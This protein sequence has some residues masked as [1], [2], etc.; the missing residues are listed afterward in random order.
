[1]SIRER[2]V[3]IIKSKKTLGVLGF[4][5]TF[6][7][8]VVVRPYLEVSVKNIAEKRYSLKELTY[9]V[10]KIAHYQKFELR[11]V[12]ESQGIEFFNL[13]LDDPFLSDYYLAKIILRNRKGSIN[14]SLRFEVSTDTRLA[15]IIDVKFKITRPAN[16]SVAIVHSLPNLMWA[17]PKVLPLQFNWEEGE[18]S[19][20][21][22]YYIYR[23]F[24][25]DRGYG[26]INHEL[27]TKSSYEF[28]GV[29]VENLSQVYY[30][31]SAVG[32]DGPESEL[33]EPITFPD[34]IAFG[35]Y[36]KDSVS[37]IP[38]QDKK[39]LSKLNQFASLPEAM[40]KSSPSTIFI[41][42]SYRK[43]VLR[44]ENL[45][46]D[47]RVFYDD[48]LEFMKGKVKISLPNGIDEGGEI[49]IFVLYKLLPGERSDLNM[50]LQEM[51]EINIERAGKTQSEVIQIDDK[52]NIEKDKKR[53]LTP[54]QVRTYLG[55]GTIFLV[56][57]KPESPD[58]KG[59]RIFRSKKR[60]WED[61]I[62]LGKELYH[63]PGL[64]QQIMCEMKRRQP[65]QKSK[66]VRDYVSFF[67]PPD[68]KEEAQRSKLVPSKVVGLRLE[69]VL[70]IEGELN[71]ADNTASPN[72]IYTYTLIAFDKSNNY[73]YPILLNASLDSTAEDTRCVIIEKPVEKRRDS[74]TEMPSDQVLR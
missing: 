7:L 58:F 65:I 69:Y 24:I 6:V 46:N 44:K 54:T 36:F 16:K 5:G 37:I 17:L 33:S 14:S 22:G 73:S 72:T 41:V 61:L 45:S 21:A 42:S 48:D 1:M 51:T 49:N 15:K 3:S 2:I 62:N 60:N 67:K 12:A 23:S 35:S 63:G 30:R 68:M 4:F 47:P 55:K 28:G 50:K 64:S 66:V 74:S 8:G 29:N 59:V 27:I 10:S 70:S 34:L 38:D 19:H 32:V 53:S 18:P 9:E 57:R 26:R 52:K 71:Y 25:K 39:N 40:A 56:W 31:V 13:K 20:I 43:E 11:E